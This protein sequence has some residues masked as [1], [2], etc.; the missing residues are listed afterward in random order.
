MIG[1]YCYEDSFNDNNIVYI[2]KD[3]NINVNLRHRRHHYPSRY[4][5]QQINRILQNNPG[6]YKYRVLKR[7][8]KNRFNKGLANAL[9]I[10]YIRRYD[11]K[12][13]FTKGGDGTLGATPWNKGMKMNEEFRQKISNVV[14][15]ENHPLYG[16]HHSEET[17]MKISKANGGKNSAWYGKH[18]K[19]ESMIKT[20]KKS[21]TTGILRVQAIKKRK[22][23]QYHYYDETGNR[24]R[25]TRKSLID[26]EK[27][28]K[29]RGLDWIIIDEQKAE[30]SLHLWDY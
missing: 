22:S 6:R 8:A 4:D 26:L 19:L 7:W 20:A 25:I 13:N 12:F 30:R 14:A 28:V 29:S 1:I 15:G 2:G 3:K 16:K 18:H 21:T 9:E 23:W 17:K 10:I 11:P 5:D 27:E 24:I